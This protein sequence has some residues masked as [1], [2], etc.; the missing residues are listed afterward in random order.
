[1]CNIG[2]V[3]ALKITRLTPVLAQFKLSLTADLESS[4]AKVCHRCA[5]IK[6]DTNLYTSVIWCHALMLGQRTSV[7]FSLLLSALTYK[8]LSHCTYQRSC[9][10]A[11]QDATASF[12]GMAASSKY[13]SIPGKIALV[14]L[15]KYPISRLKKIKYLNL[16]DTHFIDT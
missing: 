4:V 9:K 3:F 5:T 7:S 1:M 16:L 15:A 6:A 14:H 12:I 13:I 10:C 8:M 2:L 11:H